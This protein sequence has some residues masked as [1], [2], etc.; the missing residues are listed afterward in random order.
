MIWNYVNCLNLYFICVFWCFF[1][2]R[3]H[4]VIG[5]CVLKFAWK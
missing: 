2:T 5:I 1:F 4:F 3:A